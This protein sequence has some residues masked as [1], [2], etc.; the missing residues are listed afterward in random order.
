MKNFIENTLSMIIIGDENNQLFDG[1]IITK[2]KKDGCMYHR[3]TFKQIAFD[4]WN[5]GYYIG[6]INDSIV[7]EA[8]FDIVNM[9]HIL[10][11][12]CTIRNHYVDY[13]FL[14]EKLT[15][16]QI[17]SLKN[18]DEIFQKFE[19]LFLMQI[20]ENN[21]EQLKTQICSYNYSTDEIINN[22]SIA[23]RKM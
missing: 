19:A 17:E 15:N 11:C 4:L 7:T 1:K 8:G 5:E 21:K 18:F 23:K 9:G 10:F 6:K 20:D 13:L 14:P 2:G 3:D 16:K 12:N 22:N